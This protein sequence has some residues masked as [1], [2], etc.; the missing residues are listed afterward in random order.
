MSDLMNSN[1]GRE[2]QSIIGNMN[3]K[4]VKEVMDQASKSYEELE[5][6]HN[7]RNK[8]N[9][10][11]NLNDIIKLE[12]ERIYYTHHTDN[13]NIPKKWE[14]HDL[15]VST[16]TNFSA[17]FKKFCLALGIDSENFK[18][19]K[20]YAFKSESKSVIHDILLNNSEYIHFLKNGV[21]KKYL[22]Y[23]NKINENLFYFI[24]T[25]ITDFVDY[26][27]AMTNYYLYFLVNS[28]IEVG[29]KS[30]IIDILTAPDVN[31]SQKLDLMDYY[32]DELAELSDEVNS[33]LATY[34]SYNYN[35]YL[36]Q[37][38]RVQIDA[39]LANYL[40]NKETQASAPKDLIIRLLNQ[41]ELVESPVYTKENRNK[42]ISELKKAL[43]YHLTKNIND[44]N[45][46][47]DSEYFYITSK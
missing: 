3:T 6:N 11:L 2:L 37:E 14:D 33:K 27:T 19:G 35:D 5:S 28:N 18:I 21:N 31:N 34:Q 17:N 43:N 38:H 22:E 8:E 40:T 39:N 10:P 44:K 32:L 15:F 4:D 36:K 30:K 41:S 42:L 29:I 46:L 45:N 24:K 20:S 26:E 13:E 23:T 9:Y 7:N 12:V 16:K 47:D 25:E 1:W